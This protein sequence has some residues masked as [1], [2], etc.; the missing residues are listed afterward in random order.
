LKQPGLDRLLKELRQQSGCLFFERRQQAG[1]LKKALNTMPL[2]LGLLADQH[3][4]TGGTVANFFGI[5]CS[6]SPAPAI[7]A[8]RYNCPLNIAICYRTGLAHWHI[9]VHDAI[10]TEMDGQ[11]RS[12]LEITQD[13]NNVFEQAVRRDPANWFWVHR[14]WKSIPKQTKVPAQERST[15]AI[16]EDS[17]SQGDP[18]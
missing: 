4:G 16:K 11:P 17:H 1:E 3:A 6:T 2:F 8:L 12:V 9:E 13:I 5:P 14:R 10:P 7:F 18:S 15:P